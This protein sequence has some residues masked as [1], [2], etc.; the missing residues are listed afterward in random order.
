MW[1]SIEKWAYPEWSFPL[2]VEHPGLTLGFDDEFF[3]RAAGVIEF[4]L[5][6]S[7]IW[8]PLVRRAAAIMLAAMFVSAAFEF[9]KLDVIGHAPIVV[10]LIAIVGDHAGAAKETPVPPV[11]ARRTARLLRGARRF[12]R[13]LLPRPRGAVPHPDHLSN[14]FTRT[15]SFIFG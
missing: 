3:M 1:A 9:G 14:Q 8:T 6:F 4:T 2:F 15:T 11:R 5:A 12:P 13:G 7:L 10:V